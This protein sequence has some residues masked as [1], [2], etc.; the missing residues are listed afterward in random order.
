[1]RPCGASCRDA[2]Q[3]RQPGQEQHARDTVQIAEEAEH[4][5]EQAHAEHHHAVAPRRALVADQRVE[6]R[7]RAPNQQDVGDVA[8]NH[9]TDDEAGVTRQR[10]MDRDHELW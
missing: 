1:M 7:R 5:E 6:D 10:R 2:R 3:H 8:A 4:H 9:V